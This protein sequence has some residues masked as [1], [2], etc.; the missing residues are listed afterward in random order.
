M[1]HLIFFQTVSWYTYCIVEGL[2]QLVQ[3]IIIV[4][5]VWRFVWQNDVVNVLLRDFKKFFFLQCQ[6]SQQVTTNMMKSLCCI[7]TSF[8]KKRS[9]ISKP[10]WSVPT[11]TLLFVFVPDLVFILF[12]KKSGVHVCTRVL[13]LYFL[14]K[15]RAYMCAP[16]STLGPLLLSARLVRL[17]FY[18]NNIPFSPK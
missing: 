14:K 18:N 9:V 3:H 12:E 6:V 8:K 16:V 15:N 11:P 2:L 17:S 5:F 13:C 7:W 10:S 1:E 4:R